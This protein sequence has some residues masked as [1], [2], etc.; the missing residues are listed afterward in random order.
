MAGNFS[1]SGKRF[2][3]FKL[4]L[5]KENVENKHKMCYNILISFSEGDAY[6][7]IYKTGNNEFLYEAA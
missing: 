3:G 6:V 1:I 5:P 7:K 2:T 4:T